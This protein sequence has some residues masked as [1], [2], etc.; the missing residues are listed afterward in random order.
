MEMYRYSEYRVDAHSV[1][2]LRIGCG[3]TFFEIMRVPKLYIYLYLQ[4]PSAHSFIIKNN[5][6]NITILLIK[7][8]INS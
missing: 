7:T 2:V 3:G 5:H 1:R 8:I 4:L 6:F